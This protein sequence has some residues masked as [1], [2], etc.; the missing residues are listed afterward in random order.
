MKES[1]RL[2]YPNWWCFKAREDPNFVVKCAS[3]REAEATD[4]TAHHIL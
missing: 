2:R 1:Y 4:F 3:S